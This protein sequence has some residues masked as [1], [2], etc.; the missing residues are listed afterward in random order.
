MTET[1]FHTGRFFSHGQLHWPSSKWSEQRK[2]PI[3]CSLCL[4]T[5]DH[6][7]L[8]YWWTASIFCNSCNKKS[9]FNN[10]R[11]ENYQ[12]EWLQ[13]HIWQVIT[14]STSLSISIPASLVTVCVCNCLL[15]SIMLFHQQLITCYIAWATFLYLYQFYFYAPAWYYLQFSA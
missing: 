11:E 9:P 15:R 6:Q 4:M 1:A 14:I 13:R 2:Y 8:F 5:P 10:I 3:L 12:S 7:H